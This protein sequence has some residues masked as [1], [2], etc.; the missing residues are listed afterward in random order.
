MIRPSS[1]S[2]RPGGVALISAE[3]PAGD[4]QLFITGLGAYLMDNT[5]LGPVAEVA[6]RLNRWEFLLVVA[7]IATPGGTGSIVNPLA[8]F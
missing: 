2:S 7:P 5:D 1:P 8:M 6:A 4:H 3:Y